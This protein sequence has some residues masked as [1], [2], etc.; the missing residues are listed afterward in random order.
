M[1]LHAA[2]TAK[3]LSNKSP[4]FSDERTLCMLRYRLA[5]HLWQPPFQVQW[6]DVGFFINSFN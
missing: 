5:V 2:G 6:M 1:Y 3:S 4:A